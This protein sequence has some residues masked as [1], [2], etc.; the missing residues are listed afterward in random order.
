MAQPLDRFMHKTGIVAGAFNIVLNPAFAWLANT[1][2]ADVP[3]T[4]GD[5]VAVDTAFTCI[6]LSVLVSLFIT[7]ETRKALASGAI[8]N[9]PDA[10]RPGRI[11]SR[12]SSRAWIL[13]L[14]I[15][16][17]AAVLVMPYTVGLFY[18]FGV[19]TMP[20]SAFVVFKAVYTPLLAYA[21]ARWV[22]VRQ[23]AAA[24]A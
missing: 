18:L 8:A 22:I 11:L 7:A 14:G 12:V 21:V 1:R 10:P 17:G 23:L 5:S 3:L 13:G 24:R 6:I 9:T 4:G 2:M 16:A 15:G 19:E 20:F